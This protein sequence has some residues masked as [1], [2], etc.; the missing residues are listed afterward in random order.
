MATLNLSLSLSLCSR[1]GYIRVDSILKVNA[2]D[3]NAEKAKRRAPARVMPHRDRPTS[4]STI[5]PF[6][7]YICYFDL[8]PG[9]LFNLRNRQ[10]FITAK[11]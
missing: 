5:F 1:Q 3:A 9:R 2:A 11:Q 4:S 7:S 6:D 8:I 10:A